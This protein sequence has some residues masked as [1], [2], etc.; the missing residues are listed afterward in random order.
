MSV[1]H[2]LILLRDAQKAANEILEQESKLHLEEVASM[3]KQQFSTTRTIQKLKESSDREQ[4][5]W[6]E[7]ANRVIEELRQENLHLQKMHEL[8]QVRQP[9]SA[10]CRLS[11]VSPIASFEHLRF[12]D[13]EAL[14]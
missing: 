11:V 10:S 8:A 4:L 1:N 7:H 14:Q 13:A 2:G 6:K 3:K 5:E 9:R 12:V